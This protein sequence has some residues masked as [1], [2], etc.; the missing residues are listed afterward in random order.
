MP[1]SL[2]VC[3]LRLALRVFCGRP[4]NP[5]PNERRQQNRTFYLNQF[6][7]DFTNGDMNC[8]LSCLFM[9]G[10][11]RL[12]SVYDYWT[13][14]TVDKIGMGYFFQNRMKQY[15]FCEIFRCLDCEIDEMES[16][17][18]ETFREVWEPG[19]EIAADESIARA[20][21]HNNPHHKHAPKM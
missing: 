11:V 17:L 9:M 15:K 10:V 19:Y 2:L 20:T 4:F 18:N 12:P 6:D 7:K 21:M 13:S 14:P 8:F 1:A 3:W 5:V 16:L